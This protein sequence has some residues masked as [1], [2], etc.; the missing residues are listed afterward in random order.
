MTIIVKR[1]TAYF[2]FNRNFNMYQFQSMRLYRGLNK[3]S[4][5][6]CKL[7]Q[8]VQLVWIKAGFLLL[9][10]L[11]KDSWG[12]I[13]LNLHFKAAD[14]WSLY[15]LIWYPSYVSFNLFF[16]V[17]FVL[18]LIFYSSPI[19]ASS[20]YLINSPPF[21]AYKLS[22]GWSQ[23]RTKNIRKLSTTRIFL[24]EWWVSI[25]GHIWVKKWLTVCDFI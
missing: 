11:W 18:L 14:S 6:W 12:C 23:D 19:F 8:A 17:D 25:N 7:S 24:I 2:L 10:L 1:K 21:S 9:L 13:S 5:W 20:S 4:K 15:L 22:I 3:G 16:E